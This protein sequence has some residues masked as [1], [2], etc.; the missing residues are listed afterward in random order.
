MVSCLGMFSAQHS[1]LAIN[2]RPFWFLA[3]PG[4]GAGRSRHGL[5]SS[6]ACPSTVGREREDIEVLPGT[7]EKCTLP[8]QFGVPL[9]PQPPLPTLCLPL[10]P[11]CPHPDIKVWALCP[12]SSL[13]P[14]HSAQVIRK[15]V[16]TWHHRRNGH[17]LGQTPGNGEGQRGLACCSPWGRKESDTAG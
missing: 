5:L 10:S 7:L 9:L 13:L 17:E 6:G 16:N 2:F 11:L 8:L 3:V 14:A 12:L 1:S 4:V 15:E